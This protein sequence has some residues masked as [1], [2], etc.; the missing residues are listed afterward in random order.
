MRDAQHAGTPNLIVNPEFSG[1]GAAPE[2]WSFHTPRPELG[3]EHAVIKR[4]DGRR[5]LRLGATRDTRAFACWRGRAPVTPG[6]WYRASVRVRLVNIDDP[7]LS[8][9]AHFARH[10]LIPT[11]PWQ[12]ETVLHQL[13]RSDRDHAFQGDRF[14]IYLRA[15]RNGHI[16]ISDPQVVAIEPPTFRVPRVATVR[17][18]SHSGPLTLVAQRARLKTHLDLAGA[19]GSDI[20]ATTEF[21]PVIGVPKPDYGSLAAV[22]EPVPSG[23]VCQ[24][25]AEAAKRHRMYVLVGNIE[26]RGAHVFN[27]AVLF[28]RDGQFVGQYDKTHLTF[29][30]LEEGVSC[31]DSYPVFDLDFGRIAIHICYDE[32]F[33]EVAR[34]YAHQ[35]AEILFLCVAGL[36]G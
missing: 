25:A 34:Y 8:V 28:G 20:V 7:T 5:A 16:E 23:P 18:G 24:V 35:G 4:A 17:F 6:T 30:E 31:G 19:L 2:S 26:R 14:E 11:G 10:Y 22:A 13:V 3:L 12:E 32:W 15:C 21:T 27:T 29:G 9:F 33:P 36:P 1:T